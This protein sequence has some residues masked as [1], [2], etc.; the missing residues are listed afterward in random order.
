MKTFLQIISSYATGILLLLVPRS[1][2][3]IAW[4]NIGLGTVLVIL[5]AILGAISEK[6]S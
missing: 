5:L 2:P 1:V 3:F 6:K 4:F